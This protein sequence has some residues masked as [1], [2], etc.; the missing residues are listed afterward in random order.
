MPTNARRGYVWSDRYFSDFIDT[1]TINGVFQVFRGRS[2][3]RQ[4]LWG[5][6]FIGSFVG[7]IVTFGY[8]FKQYAE[9]P[10]AS[11][12]TLLST[13]RDGFTF[14]AVTICNLNVYKNPAVSSIIDNETFTLIQYLFRSG[15]FLRPHNITQQCQETIEDNMELHEREDL[16]NLLLPPKE[17]NFIHYCG[18]AYETSSEVIPCENKF[19]PVLTPAGICYT[20][21][22][23]DEEAPTVN[24]IGSRYGLELVL[25][26]E[27]E[28]H[29]T[30]SGKAGA[31]VIVHERN[32][33]PRP[34]LYGISVPP[35]QNA[36]IAIQRQVFIDRTD[37]NNCTQGEEVDFPFLP[38]V[39]YSQFACRKNELFEDLASE[40]GCGCIPSPY[41]PSTGRY[42]NTPNCTL[43]DLCCL[44][45]EFSNYDRDSTCQLPCEYTVY[46]SENS[47]SAFPEGE[48]LNQIASTMDMTE[49][50]V[51]NNFLSVH[52]FLEEL[53]TTESITRY[54]YG[55]VDLL[56]DLGGNMG[57]FLGISI[58]SI[59]EVLVLVLDEIKK[60]VC[61]K[62]VTQKLDNFDNRL[63]K[64]IPDVAISD[65]NSTQPA[66]DADGGQKKE[67]ALTTP[68]NVVVNSNPTDNNLPKDRSATS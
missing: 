59:M 62:K 32:D 64:Y 65:L 53:Q 36:D 47:Y 40:S 26:I 27:Q 22:L 56:G 2:K 50:A 9:K 18:L 17:N 54:T 35:G 25:N 63:R 61:P 45:E 60:L 5:L 30:F 51:K 42:A 46:K 29:P 67:A 3:I 52:V 14:P 41:R 16:W 38:N 34:T 33:I 49:E 1:T 23:S 57:L 7:C 13:D 44:I 43:N 24:A 15:N 68:I 8:S 12:I 58:I 37:Q 11:T 4:I 6:L 21:Q 20:L 31:A 66:I 39:V 28:T 48:A 10:T 19:Y 55:E